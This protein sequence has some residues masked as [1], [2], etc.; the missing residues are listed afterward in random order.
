[1]TVRAAPAR[2]CPRPRLAL[3]RRVGGAP[4]LAAFAPPLTTVAS[5]FGAAEYFA[6]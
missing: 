3:F 2:R 5:N 1:M 6:S 4:V